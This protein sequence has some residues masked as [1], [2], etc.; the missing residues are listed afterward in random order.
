VVGVTWYEAMAY[1]AWLTER[2]RES[3]SRRIGEWES[4][5]VVVRLPAEAEWEWA[6]GGPRHTV[7]PWNGR[8]DPDRANTLEGR[9]LGTSPVG[10]YPHGAAACGALD[11]AGNVWEWTLSLYRDYPYRPDDGREDPLAEGRRVLRGGSWHDLQ[12]YARV[13]YRLIDPPGYFSTYIGFR[14]VCSPV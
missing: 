7:Y 5:R 12:R 10:A 3:A 8:F 6:A 14:V 2:I 11:M 1:C 13:S 9:V 4:G